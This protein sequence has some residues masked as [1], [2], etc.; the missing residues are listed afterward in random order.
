MPSVPLVRRRSRALKGNHPLEILDL[1]CAVTCLSRDAQ[2]RDAYLADNDIGDTG[3][4]S[5]AGALKGNSSLTSLDLS[6]PVTCLSRD[7]RSRACDC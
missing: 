1:K 4:T 5:I 2:S 6:G 7:V 3:A